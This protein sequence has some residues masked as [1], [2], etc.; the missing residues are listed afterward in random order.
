MELEFTKE[1]QDFRQE[2]RDFCQN[3]KWAKIA[4]E[5]EKKYE[6][7]SPTF[8]RELG[9]KGWLGLPFPEKYG[10]K[11]KDALYETIFLEEISYCRAP[12]DG[13]AYAM[14]VEMLANIIF[15]CGTE[16]QKL[17]FLPR[18]FSGELTTSL[19]YTEPHAGSDLSA[20]ETTAIL[21]GD[22]YLVN[23]QKMFSTCMYY[24][25]GIFFARTNTK[26][27]PEKGISIFIL[28][29]NVP[30]ITMTPIQTMY[31]FPT[32]Q[33]F[34]DDV[35]VHKEFLIGEENHGWDYYVKTK[36]NYWHKS[37]VF[38]FV[39]FQLKFNKI[40]EYVRETEINGYKPRKDPLVRQKIAQMAIDVEAQRYLMY[41]LAWLKSKGLDTSSCSAVL[42]V[43]GN[44]MSLRA[45]N[46][47]MQILGLSG[48]LGQGVSYA[49]LSGTMEWMYRGDVI[50]H[51]VS[52]GSFI[53]KNSL[54]YDCLGLP[55]YF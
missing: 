3:E 40:V 15:K 45:N 10:G 47:V 9:K 25:Y 50:S 43:I 18:I 5:D 42:N 1:Q 54:A 39:G 36:M 8:Y 23:G 17:E 46:Y 2:V 51:F 4:L 48:Q 35:K 34:L 16:R 19:M 29:K 28:D 44:D 22:Y 21:K 53:G 30:G 6:Q 11:G 49:P 20:I 7:P 27:P 14:T 31:G 26:V 12:F 38:M 32:N 24:P 33:V 37:R 55:K 52:G 13:I 41:R